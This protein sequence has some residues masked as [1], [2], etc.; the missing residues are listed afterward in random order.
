MCFAES[1]RGPS[2]S[3]QS[4][5]SVEPP[6][7]QKRGGARGTNFIGIELDNSESRYK[8]GRTIIATKTFII[9]FGVNRCNS[10]FNL[11]PRILHSIPFWIRF[12]NVAGG[13]PNVHVNHPLHSLER[14]FQSSTVTQ[15]PFLNHPDN[16]RRPKTPTQAPASRSTAGR[17]N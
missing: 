1:L 16:V 10:F 15:T 17:N 2:F 6:R 5:R 7:S 13:S 11:A 12:K 8:L 14:G 3:C 9:P 4:G